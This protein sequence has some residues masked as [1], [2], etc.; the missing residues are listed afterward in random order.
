[1]AAKKKRNEVIAM[2]QRLKLMNTKPN[3]KLTEEVVTELVGEHALP[4]VDFLRGKTRI[5]EFIIA[6][7]LEKEINET[8][9]ILYK[10]LEHNIVT[11]IRKKDRIKGWYICYWDLNEYMIPQ[12]AAKISRQKLEKMEERLAKE[13][14]GT[15]YMCANACSRVDFDRAMEFEFKCPECG[16]LMSQQ[17]N[18]RTIEFLK[19]RIKE[20]KKAKKA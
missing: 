18:S 6:E 1:M 5:S 8:R 2:N 11:F 10:L 7:E 4:I 20:L 13:Q 14:S 12:L 17:D 15:F 19:D 3:R 16:G 9:N